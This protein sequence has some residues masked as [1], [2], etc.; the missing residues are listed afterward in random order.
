MEAI[1]GQER[2]AKQ[3]WNEIVVD[4]GIDRGQ[5]II[6]KYGT[7]ALLG[8]TIYLTFS[9]Q[10]SCFP[11]LDFQDGKTRLPSGF[12]EFTD[13]YCWESESEN[14]RHPFNTYDP[15]RLME[16]LVNCL[17]LQ[18]ILLQLPFFYWDSSTGGI[19]LGHLK[20]L[21]D[22]IKDMADLCKRLEMVFPSRVVYDK[23]GEIIKPELTF[24]RNREP[25]NETLPLK[26]ASA[27]PSNTPAKLNDLT[28]M[29][30]ILFQNI[31]SMEQY[32]Y[33]RSVIRMFR[34]YDFEPT[35]EEK[36][37]YQPDRAA[38]N[39]R[40][41]EHQIE[42]LMGMW[43]NDDNLTSTYLPSRYLRKHLLTIAV[44]LAS[45]MV[46]L[47]SG[48]LAAAFRHGLEMEDNKFGCSLDDYDVKA[49]CFILGHRELAMLATVNFAALIII[50]LQSIGAL[51][52]LYCF[53]L[54][55][56]SAKLTN[57]LRPEKYSE[58]E[59]G[60]SVPMEIFK[61]VDQYEMEK[62]QNNPQKMTIEIVG[63]DVNVQGGE[64]REQ[65]I[66]SV[67]RRTNAKTTVT[68]AN[69]PVKL[70]SIEKGLPGA[71]FTLD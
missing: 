9:P 28:F 19:I 31:A 44:S 53:R 37:R 56:Q 16:N 43:W 32:P 12:K 49:K 64:I 39:M 51:I 45:M 18:L 54:T 29:N 58:R 71:E 70:P 1:E 42:R 24:G 36:S 68:N 48:N 13:T 26:Q 30:L 35:E 17:L 33:V 57:F 55:H 5:R 61:F 52:M 2:A 59:P 60:L 40:E 7:V 50:I 23:D 14:P 69:E 10:I 25:Q 8:A 6:A 67:R 15:R 62:A 20:Y 38:G 65:R 3:S 46:L 63:N 41:K 11:I 4:F 66:S 21:Q 27:R 47:F 34:P 22:L